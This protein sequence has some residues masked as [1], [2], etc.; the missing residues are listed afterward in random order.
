MLKSLVDEPGN[1]IL[2]NLEGL[3]SKFSGK[4]PKNFLG[5]TQKIKK[6]YKEISAKLFVFQ[7]RVCALTFINGS[8]AFTLDSVRLWIDHGAIKQIGSFCVATQK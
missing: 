1:T 7:T 6:F 8:A 2:A 4:C 5:A 3:I